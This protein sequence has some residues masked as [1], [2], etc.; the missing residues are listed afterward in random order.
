M[1]RVLTF[2]ASFVV[3]IV[4]VAATAVVTAGVKQRFSD[5]PNR[6]FSGGP[7]EDGEL[8]EGPE[9]DWVF[10]KDVSTIELQLLDPPLSRRIWT[11]AHDGRLFVWSGYMGSFVGQLWKRWPGQA[12]QDGRAMIRINNTRYRRHLSRLTSGDELDAIANAVTDKYPSQMTRAAI[13]SGDVWLFEAG[14]ALQ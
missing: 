1:T 5:G 8:Y 6:V 4:I 7:L 14:P 12:E 13:E 11:V 10:T 2:A 9:P 3:C